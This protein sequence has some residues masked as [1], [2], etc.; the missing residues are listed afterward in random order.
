MINFKDPTSYRVP[1][2]DEF[3]PGFE[4]YYAEIIFKKSYF[5]AIPGL[6]KV[7]IGSMILEARILEGNLDNT[8]KLII[9]E[10]IPN[11]SYFNL[12]MKY[13][14]LSLNN[15]PISYLYNY[16]GFEQSF[17]NIPYEITKVIKKGIW[18]T[19]WGFQKK[20]HLVDAIKR[21]Q[22]WVNGKILSYHKSNCI[23]KYDWITVY[24]SDYDISKDHYNIITHKVN[25]P[26]T[27]LNLFSKKYKEIILWY[28]YFSKKHSYTFLKSKRFY[29]LKCIN[30]FLNTKHN[31]I[32]LISCSI[33]ENNMFK[34]K[35]D[36]TKVNLKDINSMENIIIQNE[37]TQLVQQLKIFTNKD[38]A[39]TH[40]KYLKPELSWKQVKEI[41][42]SI[43]VDKLKKKVTITK[44]NDHYLALSKC[45][46]HHFQFSYAISGK[47]TKEG[48]PELEITK[49]VSGISL[50]A[51]IRRLKRYTQD[52]KQKYITRINEIH[53]HTSSNPT[54]ITIFSKK[55]TKTKSLKQ[56]KKKKLNKQYHNKIKGINEFSSNNKLVCIRH[57]ETGQVLRLPRYQAL[58]KIEGDWIW[59]NKTAFKKANNKKT[60]YIKPPNPNLLKQQEKAKKVA[61]KKIIKNDM[62]LEKALI[63]KNKKSKKSVLKRRHVYNNRSRKIKK[64]TNVIV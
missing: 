58:E 20:E 60:L 6:C 30:K 21:E 42:N 64:E 53:Y 59:S 14:N 55:N 41:I 45:K 49:I 35:I 47:F 12:T 19:G 15:F 9:T 29:S 40:L 8:V 11:K 13:L 52:V 39:R 56:Q 1:F 62:N 7:L 51:A 28:D 22:V 48:I 36:L 37:D 50:K 46:L 34:A 32:R 43:W 54:I 23:N 24:Y 38:K 33:L 61:L 3:V 31:I 16:E 5:T 26:I 63:K 18:K 4:Y 17:K 25:A 2:I 44:M 57:I 10:K 27:S